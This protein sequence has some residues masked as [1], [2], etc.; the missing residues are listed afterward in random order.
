MDIYNSTYHFSKL[1]CKTEIKE[2]SYNSTVTDRWDPQVSWPHM[3]AKQKTEEH[4]GRRFLA[5]DDLS[6]DG[7]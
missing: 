2:L 3:S 1:A 4:M 7:T 6:S 5:G